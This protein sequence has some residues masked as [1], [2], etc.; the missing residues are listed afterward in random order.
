MQ[1]LN[2]AHKPWHWNWW[3][4]VTGWPS[5]SLLWVRLTAL[6]NSPTRL[7]RW[8]W[9]GGPIR[10]RPLA[11]TCPCSGGKVEVRLTASARFNLPVCHSYMGY[12]C[13]YSSMR[14]A[15]IHCVKLLT[16]SWTHLC[17]LPPTFDRIMMVMLLSH[18][19]GGKWLITRNIGCATLG[20]IICVMNIIETDVILV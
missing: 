17:Q 2:C 14:T 4:K 16:K 6:W 10:R 9:A 11:R 3:A 20:F 1:K 15:Y 8:G 12:C 5:F 18:F 13:L 7:W 19:T